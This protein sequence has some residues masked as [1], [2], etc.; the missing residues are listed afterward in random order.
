MYKNLA[1][2]ILPLLFF[3]LG[4]VFAQPLGNQ[5]NSK[6]STHSQSERTME[7]TS[8]NSTGDKVVEAIDDAFGIRLGE[9]FTPSMVA[10]VLS[11][12]QHTYKGAGATELHGKLYQIIPKKPDK[13]FQDYFIRTTNEGL[14][15]AIEG[16][17]QYEVEPAQGKKMGRI[18]YSRVIRSVCK[19]AVE[20]LAEELEDRYGKPR[21]KGWDGE[22][23]SFRQF[24][25]TSNK[26]L[27]LYANRCRT[28]LYSIIY[29]DEIVQ[30]GRSGAPQN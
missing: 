28:G 21:G 22:W 13:R 1:R 15:Y 29:K 2:L 16:D 14:I 23:F 19:S 3:P 8:A 25:E 10:R 9:S 7:S 12:N 26:S 4:L 17:Y 27:K 5:T 24:S 6:E 18:K 11:Q 30:R 20:S